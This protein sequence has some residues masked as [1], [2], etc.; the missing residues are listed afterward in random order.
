MVSCAD[1]VL[2]IILN[3]T[4]TNIL[5]DNLG[6]PR[7]ISSIFSHTLHHH[8]KI[9]DMVEQSEKIYL[10]K[11]TLQTSTIRTTRAPE[12]TLGPVLVKA[13]GKSVA[14]VGWDYQ[15]LIMSCRCLLSPDVHLHCSREKHSNN[16]CL[17]K[18]V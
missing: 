4:I 6:S 8:W 18:T 3:M 9:P 15:Q 11:N 16:C 5:F 1:A 2:W 14:S 17:N 10:V 12:P 13:S 7:R